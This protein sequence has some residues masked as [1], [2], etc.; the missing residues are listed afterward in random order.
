MAS[1]GNHASHLKKTSTTANVT[2]NQCLGGG[3]APSGALAGERTDTAFAHIRIR[4]QKLSLLTRRSGSTLKNIA[5]AS[6]KYSE[7]R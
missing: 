7:Q 2:L 1:Q 5:P 4:S 6:I 3:A